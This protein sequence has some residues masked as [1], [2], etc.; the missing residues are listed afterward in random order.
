MIPLPRLFQ[1]EGKCLYPRFSP[2]QW[3]LT[4]PSRNITP[5]DPVVVSLPTHYV[6]KLVATIAGDLV[7]LGDHTGRRLPYSP[8]PRNWIIGKVIFP[9]TPRYLPVD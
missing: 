8:V 3:V 2:G 4:W 7:Q 6:L 5:G 9:R 1:V